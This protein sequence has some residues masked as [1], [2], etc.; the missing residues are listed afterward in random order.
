MSMMI[1]LAMTDNL[2]GLY[3]EPA[4]TTYSMEPNAP[5]MTIDLRDLL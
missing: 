4:F 1:N 3:E 5:N 2:L